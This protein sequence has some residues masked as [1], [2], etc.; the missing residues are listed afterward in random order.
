MYE[1]PKFLVFCT[2]QFR[3]IIGQEEL[4]K[5]L[6]ESV[7]LGRVSHAQLFLG[8][9]GSGSLALAVAY[10]QY[11]SCENKGASD[12]CGNAALVVSTKN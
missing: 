8:P 2:M 1:K 10:A 9:E 12:S 11:I 4:K 7:Q 6:I 5:H 3:A